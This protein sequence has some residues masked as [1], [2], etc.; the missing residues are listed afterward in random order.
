MLTS[1][2]PKLTVPPEELRPGLSSSPH[3]PTDVPVPVTLERP[4]VDFDVTQDVPAQLRVEGPVD[5]EPVPHG[6]QQGPGGAP[7]PCIVDRGLLTSPLVRLAA[8]YLALCIELKALGLLPS[9]DD[10]G[11]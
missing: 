1:C 9:E 10:L 6:G 3:S 11:G 8:R 7:G 4:V 2:A 5:A